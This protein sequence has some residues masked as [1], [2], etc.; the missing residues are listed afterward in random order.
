[1]IESNAKIVDKWLAGGMLLMTQFYM[2]ELSDKSKSLVVAW[3][4]LADLI[5]LIQKASYLYIRLV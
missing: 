2:E 4:Q 5:D 3:N 1:M